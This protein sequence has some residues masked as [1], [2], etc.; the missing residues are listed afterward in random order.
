MEGNEY[1]TCP[2]CDISF[3]RPG[4]IPP[5]HTGFLCPECRRRR[6][7]VVGV[8]LFIPDINLNILP[9]GLMTA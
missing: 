4:Y 9:A 3:E 7:T 2:K 5:E 8:V 1:A 6:Y